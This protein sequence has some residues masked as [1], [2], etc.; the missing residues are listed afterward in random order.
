MGAVDFSL[1]CLSKVIE[2]HGNV[3]GVLTLSKENASFHS[4]YA[5]LSE[6]ASNHGIP[7]FKITDINRTETIELIKSLN[8]DI[9]FVF[10]WSQIIKKEILS[11]PNMG[12]IGTHPAMLPRNRGRHPIVWALVQGLDTSGVTFFYLDESADSGDI[13]WQRPFTISL[14]DDASSV[15]QKIKTLAGQGIHEFL[16]MLKSGSAPRTPQDN[17]LATYWRKREEKDGEIDWS[18]NSLVIHNLIRGLARPYV[19]AHTYLNGEKVLIW[20]SYPPP[21]SIPSEPSNVSELPGTIISLAGNNLEISTGDGRLIV[22]DWEH[23]KGTQ[24][25]QGQ[26]LGPES[27]TSNRGVPR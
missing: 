21:A 24:F 17:S 13:L 27:N 20:H 26:Q 5:D 22:D 25:G 9:I 1:Y 16:P 4:D 11:L 10:G 2:E 3:V 19:G 15:Y 8:P 6:L 14:D 18:S 23:P 12:C 7:V